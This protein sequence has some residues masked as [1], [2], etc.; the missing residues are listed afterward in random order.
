[1]KILVL[2]HVD[3]EHPGIFRDFMT[4]DGLTW[5][6]VE[7]DE[8]E[9]IPDLQ[10]YDL[11]IVMGGPQDVWQEDEYPWFK[12]EKEAIRSFVVDLK[13]PFLGVC[14]GHQLLADALGGVV[15]PA[16]QPEVGILSITKTAEGMQDPLFAGL[17]ETATVLQWHC[18]EVTT[19][20]PGCVVLASSEKCR[21]QAI[22]YGDHAYGMQFHV[23]LTQQTV[24]D[25]AAIPTYAKALEKTLGPGA[26]SGLDLGVKERL[27]QFNSDARAIYRALMTMAR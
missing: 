7:L 21:V 5:D 13:R 12:A 4:A 16:R 22:R 18:A 3:V 25:W 23:E 19:A 20:P 9:R 11:M 2:Q 1:M 17:A 15:G 8:G 14:L 26:V 27:E 6:T 24:A 10:P